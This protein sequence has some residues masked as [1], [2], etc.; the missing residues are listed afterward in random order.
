VDDSLDVDQKWQSFLANEG[1][2]LSKEIYS[3]LEAT[4]N[5]LDTE[6]GTHAKWSSD[7][8]LGLLLVFDAEEADMLISAYSAGMDGNDGAQSSFGCW[9]AGVMGVLD[10]CL[11]EVPPGGWGEGVE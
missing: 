7:G 5:L 8:Q 1:W 10:A 3:T 4:S 6:D 11:T 2:K 9:V